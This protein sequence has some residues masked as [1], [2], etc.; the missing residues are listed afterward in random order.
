MSRILT[1]LGYRNVMC[2]PKPPRRVKAT[3][4]EWKRIREDKLGPCRV[5]GSHP[6]SLHHILPK[7]LGGDDIADN[8]APLCGT[9]TTGCHGRIEAFEPWACTIFGKRLTD[10]EKAYVTRK[11]GA[12]Y[13]TD[14]YGV[15]EA[16]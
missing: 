9:G 15:K 8:C 1:E 12:Y 2:D 5:C 7:S 13:L 6:T 10:A 4:A 14:R 3:L 11:K 16:A